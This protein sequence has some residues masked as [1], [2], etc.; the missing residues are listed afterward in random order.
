MPAW[1]KA[2]IKDTADG[3]IWLNLDRAFRME[4]RRNCTTVEIAGPGALVHYSVKET[5]E[6]LLHQVRERWGS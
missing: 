5:P 1:V 6:E 2:T 4:P 3:V